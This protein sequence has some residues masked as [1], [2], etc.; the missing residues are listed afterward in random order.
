MLFLESWLSKLTIIERNIATIENPNG[1]EKIIET[2]QWTRGRELQANP[3][4]PSGSKTPA[5]QQSGRRSSG[6]RGTPPAAASL[7]MYRLLSKIV[8]PM[9][10]IVPR[11]IGRKA[12]PEIPGDQP[13]AYSYTNGNA[14]KKQSK[15]TA[16]QYGLCWQGSGLRLKKHP[17]HETSIESKEQADRLS[18]EEQEGPD[19]G[20]L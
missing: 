9:A 17:I 8:A 19:E 6:G 7:R 10:S 16:R 1:T 13:R 5:M 20:D 14:P 18:E 3:K 4:S 2:I 11:P 12:S 15:E